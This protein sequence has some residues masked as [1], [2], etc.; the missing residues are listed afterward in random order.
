V[1]LGKIAIAAPKGLPLAFP[2]DEFADDEG[3]GN[4][5]SAIEDRVISEGGRRCCQS[6]APRGRRD[7]ASASSVRLRE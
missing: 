4:D 3:G 6:E 5:M 1:T 2:P 7:A